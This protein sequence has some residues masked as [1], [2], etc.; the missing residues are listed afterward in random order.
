MP[1]DNN[2]GN[3]NKQVNLCKVGVTINPINLLKVRTSGEYTSMTMDW[4]KGSKKKNYVRVERLDGTGDKGRDVIC[5]EDEEGKVWDNYQCKYYSRPLG[6]VDAYV[7]IGKLLFYTFKRDYTIPR[8][9][10]FVAP[11]GL[12][13]KLRDIFKDANILKKALISAWQSC[14]SKITETQFVKLEG[15]FKSYVEGFDFSIFDYVTPEEFVE[16]MRG[17][18]Y[19]SK[20]FGE[21]TK[22]RPLMD[23][24]P[25]EINMAL[26]LTYIKKILDAYSE[27]LEKNVS[28]YNEL[29]KHPELK[30]H[31]ERQRRD[32]F[33][34][35]WLK[36]FS[37]EIYEPELPVFEQLKEEIYD[38]II[39]T[40][41][42]DAKNGFER[43][44]KVLQRASGI[45]SISSPLNE[46]TL[47]KDKKG[48][49][50]HLANE[51]EDVTWRRR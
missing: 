24:Y 10:F 47:I 11:Q 22:A 39:E 32:F 30:I 48:I 28:D 14:E 4:A 2:N 34:A 29:E 40:I 27:H 19:F 23:K 50:H 5:Q 20:W 46:Y 18:A 35:E 3:D 25:E 51:R 17:T 16:Q 26:E 9:Y 36:A 49:C 38:G 33:S 7:E 44:N 1:I 12:S 8:R 43:L 41:E 31:F 6:P 15:N 37:R 21:P 13:V 42:E 45:T